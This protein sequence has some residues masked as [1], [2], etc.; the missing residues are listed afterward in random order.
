MACGNADQIA[1]WNGNQGEAW[2]RRTMT[3][4]TAF[5]GLTDALLEAAAI[6]PGDRVLDLGCGGGGSMAA[7]AE[8]VGPVGAVTAIDVSAPMIAV[9]RRR[10]EKLTNAAIVMADAATYPFAAD[11]FDALISR[12]GAMFFDD[13]VSAF[14][15]L[16]GAMA[17]NGRIA[18]GVWRQPRENPWA[19]EPISAVRPYV[20]MPPRPDPET[21]GPFSFADPDRVRRILEAAGFGE[22]SLAPLDLS[23]P[24]GSSVDEALDFAV[25]VGPLAEPL[26]KTTGERRRRAIDAIL[27]VLAAH[28]DSDGVVRLGGACWIVTARAP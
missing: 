20:D 22:I 3:V 4:D 23:L 2:A 27:D 16:R 7:V 21:P 10:A 15:P 8:R 9:A 13:P 5:A 28:A 11:S 18:L 26:S 19:M 24:F 17:A 6:G 25:D 12:L 1:F 14:A